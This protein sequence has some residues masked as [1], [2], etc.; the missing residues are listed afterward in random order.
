M[1]S[2]SAEPLK[3]SLL[4]SRVGLG[5]LFSFLAQDLF[6]KPRVIDPIDFCVLF[7][8]EALRQPRE[9]IS[10]DGSRASVV[11]LK[12]D[13]T[14]VGDQVRNPR[15]PLGLVL[16]HLDEAIKKTSLAVKEDSRHLKQR[17]S[18]AKENGASLGNISNEEEPNESLRE[19]IDWINQVLSESGPDTDSLQSSLLS[20]KFFTEISS[21]ANQRGRGWVERST[22]SISLRSISAEQQRSLQN[23]A[24][25]KLLIFKYFREAISKIEKS[26]RTREGSIGSVTK[27]AQMS[28]ANY[29]NQFLLGAENLPIEKLDEAYYL[30]RMGLLSLKQSS[31]DDLDLGLNS[32]ED[33]NLAPIKESDLQSIL[34]HLDGIFRL[35]RKK[36]TGPELGIEE[37]IKQ[38]FA[39]PVNLSFSAPPFSRQELNFWADDVLAE[40]MRRDLI[41]DREI[42]SPVKAS[43]F[44][45]ENER[46]K[47]IEANLI[48]YFMDAIR[49]VSSDL[50]LGRTDSVMTQMSVL[51]TNFDTVSSILLSDQQRR[52]DFLR[53]GERAGVE[54]RNGLAQ[55]YIN[56]KLNLLRVAI[57]SYIK[58][59]R[60][61]ALGR[62]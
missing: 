9:G 61:H 39:H 58:L 56:D 50:F 51:S 8:I 45:N 35:G 55:A 23:V 20:R 22:E 14:L 10:G 12:V 41:I 31:S 53:I 30:V 29:I 27:A 24:L 59:C 28:L 1:F 57:D 25:K 33:L 2:A 11:Q 18:S 36:V 54:G 42:G 7:S 48:K 13:G 49:L 15:S 40:V 43:H 21:E 46:R 16:V 6:A 34:V 60:P 32:Y 62:N 17:F 26:E 5:V 38:A 52:T 44:Q 19:M 4:F 47:Q 37:F 3:N